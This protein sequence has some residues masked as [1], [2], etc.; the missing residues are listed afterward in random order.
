MN[1]KSPE[2]RASQSSTSKACKTASATCVWQRAGARLQHAW[3][4]QSARARGANSVET[5][6]REGGEAVVGGETQ[7]VGGCDS[8]KQTACELDVAL[9]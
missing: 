9:L 6:S 1:W 3:K 5:L 7:G 8:G 4:L 2:Q